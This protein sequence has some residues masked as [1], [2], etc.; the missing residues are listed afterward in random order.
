VSC[1]IAR[2]PTAFRRAG[3]SNLIR[4]YGFPHYDR[5]FVAFVSRGSLVRGTGGVVSNG[6]VECVLVISVAFSVLRS[7]V[8]RDELLFRLVV[9]DNYEH[10]I[11]RSRRRVEQ[12]PQFASGSGNY[13]DAPFPIRR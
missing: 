3:A 5:R 2:V 7:R 13:D 12:V 10:V 6:S 9:P 11:E 1:G 4:D 8:V